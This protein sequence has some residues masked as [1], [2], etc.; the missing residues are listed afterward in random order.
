MYT[1]GIRAA[2]PKRDGAHAHD[3]IGSTAAVRSE[4]STQQLHQRAETQET[5]YLAIYCALGGVHCSL[6]RSRD[7][8]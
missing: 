4:V 8:E 2:H 7:K 6:N 5:L 1:D 3:S